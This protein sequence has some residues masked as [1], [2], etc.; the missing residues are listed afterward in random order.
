VIVSGQVLVK[1]RNLLTLDLE[2]VLDRVAAI[3][4]KISSGRS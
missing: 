4:R 1:N 2:D 3:A